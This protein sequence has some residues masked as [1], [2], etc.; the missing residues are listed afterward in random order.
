LAPEEL[1]GIM[2]FKSQDFFKIKN[3]FSKSGLKHLIGNSIALG[4]LTAIYKNLKPLLE[5]D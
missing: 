3:E 2:G 4:P 5:R 1:W